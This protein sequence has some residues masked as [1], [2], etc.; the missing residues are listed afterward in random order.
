MEIQD[1]LSILRKATGALVEWEEEKHPRGEGGK[2]APKGSSA[3]AGAEEKP[4]K[5]ERKVKG[6]VEDEIDD[7][8]GVWIDMKDKNWTIFVRDG[9][10]LE[11]AY[12]R[13]LAEA[14][15]GHWGK[16]A[17]K[18]AQGLKREEDRK[19]KKAEAEQKAKLKEEAAATGRTP[20]QEKIVQDAKRAMITLGASKAEAEEAVET[21]IKII[22]IKDAGDLVS[23]ALGGLP[24][25]KWPEPKPASEIKPGP[26]HE[27]SSEDEQLF[28]EIFGKPP[29][30]GDE[31]EV[32]GEVG[33]NEEVEEPSIED[34]LDEFF[35]GE[36]AP[37]P[38]KISREDD[39]A[40]D[41]LKRKLIAREEEEA[42]RRERRRNK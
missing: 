14:V 9:E 7:H 20:A 1:D 21:A 32:E 10:T 26:A 29:K 36:N 13:Q 35:G 12:A 34:R 3:S 8:K 5:P 38:P 37:A 15:E 11:E 39:R 31:D 27:A 19:R 30:W 40:M 4:E 24:G 18:F 28:E 42:A 23:V 25:N 22:G 17:Q 41:A 2:F 16:P 33:G 6:G